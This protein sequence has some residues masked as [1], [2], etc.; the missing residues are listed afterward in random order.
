MHAALRYET[1]Q[2]ILGSENGMYCFAHSSMSLSTKFWSEL[3]A[4]LVDLVK[5]IST[6]KLACQ[7]RALSVA[8]DQSRSLGYW[9]VPAPIPQSILQIKRCVSTRS[10]KSPFRLSHVSG[11]LF[12]LKL[13]FISYIDVLLG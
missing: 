6:W 3:V 13:L 8:R 2:D 11:D 9:P 7:L 5:T 12:Y 4:Q 10:N 1:L